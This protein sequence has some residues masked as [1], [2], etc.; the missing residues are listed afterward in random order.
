MPY[1]IVLLEK[2]EGG[3][4]VSVPALPACTVEADTRD[5]AIRLAREAIAT[6]V[7]RGE[8]V[9][10]E[11]PQQP[12]TPLPGD[13]GPW[14]WFEAAKDDTTW[15]PIFDEIEQNREA[16]RKGDA[17]SACFVKHSRE[18]TMYAHRP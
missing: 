12:K 2:P 11:V 17:Q 1:T 18:G 5:K 9:R 4:H 8:M 7:R 3:I 13:A 16:T 6:L 14:A 10:G 15:A